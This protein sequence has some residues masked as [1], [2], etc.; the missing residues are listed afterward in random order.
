[1]STLDRERD[2]WPG[3]GACLKN[4]SIEH[5]NCAKEMFPELLTYKYCADIMHR[6]I[7]LITRGGAVW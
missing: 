2:A 6:I 7:G 5:F 1:M 3:G 4:V